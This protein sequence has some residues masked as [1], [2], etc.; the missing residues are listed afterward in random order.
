MAKARSC[1]RATT[2]QAYAGDA[3]ISALP[4][5]QSVTHIDPAAPAVQQVS[6]TVGTAQDASQFAAGALCYGSL[7]FVAGA[8]PWSLPMVFVLFVLICIPWRMVNFCSKKY[9]FFLVDFCYVS[10]LMFCTMQRYAPCT[11]GRF[12]AIMQCSCKF[13]VLC[14]VAGT[15]L[16]AWCCQHS[17][18]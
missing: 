16:G 17:E 6:K 8:A 3:L 2:V 9:Q 10:I 4:S 12:P 1:P 14:A 18:T 5:Q 11:L 7:L 15:T 13:N